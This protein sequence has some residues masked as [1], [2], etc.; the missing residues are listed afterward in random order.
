[1]KSVAIVILMVSTFLGGCATKDKTESE[2]KTATIIKNNTSNQ[3]VNDFSVL[4]KLNTDEFGVF[5]GQFEQIN[6][7]YA[8]LDQNRNILDDDPKQLI[9]L[10][11]NSKLKMVCARV[12]HTTFNEVQ[13]K[14]NVIAKL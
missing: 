9:S 13:R 3:C 7:M 2:K 14:V 5:R 4:K 10:E 11:L 12:R 8:F 6:H 1:M